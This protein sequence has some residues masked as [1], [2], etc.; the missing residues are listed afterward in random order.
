MM[1]RTRFFFVH[2]LI[3]ISVIAGMSMTSVAQDRQMGGVGITVF[4]D[5]NFRGKSATFR[6]DVYDL[7]PLGINDKVSSLR[8]G[9]GERW[10]ICE[11]SNFQ[12]RCVVVSGDEP[13]LR[14]NSWNDTVSSMRR[15]RSGPIVPP[16]QRDPYIVLFDQVNFR[17]TPN[18][19]S[20]AVPDLYGFNRRAQSVTVGRGVWEVCE[21]RN[22]T[23]RCVTLDRSVSNLRTYNLNNRISS[24]RPIGV[25][26]ERPEPPRPPSDWY[27]VLFD[28]INYRGTPSNYNSEVEDLFGFDNRAM[29]VT[30]GRGVW[31]LCEEP[32]FGGRCITLRNSVPDL[33]VWQMRRRISSVRPLYR[34][35]R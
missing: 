9:P 31:E 8:V 2:Y 4:A 29:S 1:R 32:N 15:I 28:Q 16:P 6:Q 22:Y 19:Y 24:V 3:F 11:N 34:Q 5:R 23:G 7:E 25:V 27:I 13:D 14:T 10:E 35:P 20:G 30:I 21:G 18:N 26:V 12:G 17:G 33:R